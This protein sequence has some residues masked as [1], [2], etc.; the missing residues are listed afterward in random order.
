MNKMLQCLACLVLVSVAG[1]ASALDASGKRYAQ[2]IASGGLGSMQHAAEEIFNQGINDQELL[3]VAA[4]ALAQNYSRNA[5]GETFV[6][7]ISWM[8]KALGNSGNGR[9][10]E[11]LTKVSESGIHKKARKYCDRAADNLPKKVTPYVVGS[12]HIIRCLS[13][14]LVSCLIS[15]PIASSNF[16]DLLLLY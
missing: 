8:C 2:M 10:K 12:Y 5:N 13:A 6:D 1:G 15:L 14:L 9:Y 7:S 11:L 4:E 3:D 16:L